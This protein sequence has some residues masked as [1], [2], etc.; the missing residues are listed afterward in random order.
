VALVGASG[1]GKSTVI[2]SLLRFVDIKSGEIQIDS[3]SVSDLKLE[4]LRSQFAVV[5]QDIVLFDGSFAENVAYARQ[6]YIDRV[7]VKKCLLA[8]NLWPYVESLKN[9]IDSS[10]G[11]NGSLLSGG[12]RQR[13]AIARALYKEA[14][15]WI[16][17][18]AT[19]SLDSES[20]LVIQRAVDSLRHNKTIII[21]AHRLSTIRN[22][23]LI[24]VVSEGRIV[25]HGSHDE[26]MNLH[27]RYA[28]MISL[29]HR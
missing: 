23:D 19:S 11:V 14:A 21:I 9:G 5:S 13:L 18:E 27:G 15:I 26:L 6:Q 29:Q 3:I 8:S 24:C 10:V 4:N 22:A 2:N 16:F 17:D 7:R 12:Q 28:E 25:E 1:A 20:E